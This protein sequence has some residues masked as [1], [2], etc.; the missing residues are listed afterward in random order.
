MRKLLTIFGIIGIVF[1]GGCKKD[2]YTPVVTICPV[3]ISTNPANA[4]FSVPLNQVITAT[5]NEKIDP[6]SVTSLSF[7]VSDAPVAGTISYS[8][9]T[10]SFT[11]TGGLTANTTYIARITTA[12]KDP[13]G[14]HLQTDYVWTFSTGA[15]VNPTVIST[16]PVNNATNVPITQK[17]NATFSLPMDPT[18]ITSTNFII[19][20]GLTP[21]AGTVSYTGM[22]A[23]FSPATNLVSGAVYTATITTGVR[24][25]AGTALPANYVWTFSTGSSIVPTVISTDPTSNATGVPLNKIVAAT[26][27]VPMLP[28]TITT[29]TYTLKQGSTNISGTVSYAGTTASF[30]PTGNLLPGLVY[31]ATI[32]T[33]VRNAA[34]AALLNN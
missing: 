19:K 8:G 11:P 23:T 9:F 12:V 32:T 14:N 13:Y 33:G 29:T 10:A 28:T 24:N 5:F 22:T 31:T 34:G 16:D 3:V 18:T 25:V 15:T 17:V 7:T 20:Q 2:N 21:V 4:A 1:C 26:F 27:S 6:S 30:S